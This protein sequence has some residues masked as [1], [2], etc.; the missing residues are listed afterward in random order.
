MA[1]KRSTT[2][3]KRP[4]LNHSISD[5]RAVARGAA[6]VRILRT[7]FRGYETLYIDLFVDLI[8]E[9]LDVAVRHRASAGPFSD[10]QRR[11]LG[12]IWT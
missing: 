1:R 11:V 4:T 3:Q 7:P 6:D 12:G 10:R 9:G 8:D 2:E 5:V